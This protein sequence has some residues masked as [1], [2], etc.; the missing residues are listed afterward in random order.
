MKVTS[1]LA[2]S[3]SATDLD[4]CLWDGMSCFHGIKDLGV[5]SFFRNKADPCFQS[6]PRETREL[7]RGSELGTSSGHPI[8]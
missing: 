1:G 8:N 6:G 4:D 7:F 3:L 5:T 2:V